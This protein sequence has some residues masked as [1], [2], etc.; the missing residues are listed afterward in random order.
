LYGVI[1]K[2]DLLLGLAASLSLGLTV[3]FCV[4]LR[5]Q[6]RLNRLAAVL[7][8]TLNHLPLVAMANLPPF[9]PALGNER[10]TSTTPVSNDEIWGAIRELRA[11]EVAL[12]VGCITGLVIVLVV[13]FRGLKLALSRRSFLYLELSDNRGCVQLKLYEFPEPHCYYG[14]NVNT[15]SLRIAVDNYL[16]VM[17]VR[18]SSTDWYM[19]AF[20]S[21]IREPLPTSIWVDP[22]MGRE[23]YRMAAGNTH[24][25]MPIVV[26]SHEY[27]FPK[28]NSHV[29][30]LS[31]HSRQL[32]TDSRV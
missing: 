24:T 9:V 7:A 28:D 5:A 17:R 25:A 21:G 27:I 4:L 26:H 8:G 3:L 10:M 18:F 2:F 20:S 22:W 12:V 16:V 13:L 32:E 15:A 14:I 30:L 11:S 29:S 31:R 23:I 1:D 6:R 19:W